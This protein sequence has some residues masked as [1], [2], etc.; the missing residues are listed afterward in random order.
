MDSTP[1]SRS[2]TITSPKA[3][4]LVCKGAPEGELDPASRAEK[5]ALLV[6]RI[7]ELRARRQA[8]N[9]A[10][11]KNRQELM[12]IRRKKEEARKERLE[13]KVT[14]EAEPKEARATREGE[15]SQQEQ[16]RKGPPNSLSFSIVTFND[17]Q[18]H[19]T[20][21]NFKKT[22]RPKGPTDVLGQLRHVEAKRS[23]REWFVPPSSRTD[24]LA[25]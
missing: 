24:D 1:Q 22:W 16:L 8:A 17:E 18:L 15:T 12:E 20:L 2:T 4:E 19:A 9:G 21:T 14:E 11:A 10:G 7:E 5:H 25:Y 23:K 3:G 13:A 6:A